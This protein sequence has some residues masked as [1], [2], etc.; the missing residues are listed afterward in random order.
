MY[1]GNL[2]GL[3]TYCYEHINSMKWQTNAS[4]LTSMQWVNVTKGSDISSLFWG[5][6]QVEQR[7]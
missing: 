3:K 7:R 4:V 6:G 2:Q 1:D 5:L